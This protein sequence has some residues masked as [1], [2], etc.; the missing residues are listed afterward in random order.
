M[1][2]SMSAPARREE[3]AEWLEY[4]TTA[5]PTTLEKERAANGHPAPYK[6]AYLGI[7]N[8]SWDCGGNM[9]PEYYLEPAEDLQPL[10]PQLQSGAAGQ[11]PDAEDRRRARRRRAPLDRLD[12]NRHEGLAASH[13]GA[14]TSTAS[15]CTNYTVV[16]WP[17]P[18]KSVGFGE[19][20]YA[21]FSNPRWRWTA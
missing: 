6:V 5:Q 20:E 18:Y 9:T 10:R 17:P 19:T 14:G 1:S 15:P 3:A 2:R 13:S 7:G 8:E 4:L 16:K 21:R 11:G 12:G